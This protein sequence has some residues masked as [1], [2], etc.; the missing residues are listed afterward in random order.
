M[1]ISPRLPT[2]LLVAWLLPL[3][4]VCLLHHSSF[5]DKTPCFVSPPPPFCLTQMDED[6]KL[7]LY[8]PQWHAS[9]GH[10]P[11]LASFGRNAILARHF[12]QK[13]PRQEP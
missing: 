11:L 6:W 4:K 10:G 9:S 12:P 3:L 1:G 8:L 5:Q 13:E 7:S 2:K